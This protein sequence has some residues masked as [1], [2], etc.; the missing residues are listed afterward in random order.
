[1]NNHTSNPELNRA[2]A[3]IA[4]DPR[5]VGA[6]IQAG[7]LYS[8]EKMLEKSAFHL[9]KALAGDKKN[10][11]IL[12]KLSDVLI[13]RRQ[14]SQA[15]R[16]ARKM[17]ELKRRNPAAMHTMARVYEAMGEL[18]KALSWI[19]KALEIDPD[20]EKILDD[21]ANFFS[22][23]GEMDQSLEVHRRILE[24]NPL[25]ADSWW[26]VAQ[27]Q[28]YDKE[29]AKTTLQQI[30]MA[31]K[32][33]KSKDQLRGLHF[34]AGKIRQDIGNYSE[35]FENFEKANILHDREITADRIIAANI[36][37]RETYSKEF[38]SYA[39]NIDNENQ[40]N[41]PIFILG[42]TRSGTTLTESLCA[43]HSGISAAGELQH[44]TDINKGFDLYST[45]ENGHRTQIHG[46]TS[47]QIKKIAKEFM[48]KTRHLTAPGTRI[49]DKMPNN[50]F[51]IGLINLIFPNAKIIHCRR[52]PL[53]NC[54]SIFSNPML[55]S[56]KEYKSR[57]ETLGIY[58][59]NYVQIMEYWREIC[60][61]KIHDVFYEDLV[62]NTEAVARQM[63]NY[64][65][66][67]WEDSVM[68]RSGSQKAVKTLSVW[69]VRQPVFQSS[70]GKWLH[71]EKQLQPLRDII[72]PHVKQY[73]KE[74]DELDELDAIQRKA[75]R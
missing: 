11:L 45:V 34:A 51:Q 12:E 5:N 13:R 47:N 21:K 57:L 68:S 65:D 19:N 52:H 26:P 18:D 44:L 71:Y 20:N 56:H 61:I 2:L 8:Q 31:I 55:D 54:V 25:S 10:L 38:F 62:T 42:Q 4:R 36:N 27:L 69:Q 43:S 14:I 28:K 41:S 46:L 24:I 23:I 30:E 16:Y 22:Q 72:D 66:L 29:T 39:N 32:A 9:K 6:N 15:R 73:E 60:P 33:N 3:I 53:D 49:T 64:L 1:M 48:S 50:F 59:E 63:I 35:A 58:Y 37:I 75:D 7:V 70:K 74:L 67:E 17:F 40:Q